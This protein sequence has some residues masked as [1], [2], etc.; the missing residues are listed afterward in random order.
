MMATRL[1]PRVSF[2]S[3]LHSMMA[4]RL[5]PKSVLYIQVTLCDGHW[6]ESQECPLYPGYTVHLGTYSKGTWNS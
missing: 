4:T 1:F 5:S 2:I 6:V 3:R